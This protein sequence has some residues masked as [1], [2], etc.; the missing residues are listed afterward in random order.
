MTWAGG[1]KLVDVRIPVPDRA[2]TLAEVTRLA[3]ELQI[4]VFDLEVS[5]SLN[6]D[7]GTLVLTVS[8]PSGSTFVQSLSAHGHEASLHPRPD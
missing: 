4:E 8:A 1:S 5:R 6:T 3:A 2:N 7:R